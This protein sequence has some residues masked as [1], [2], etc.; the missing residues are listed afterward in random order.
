MEKIIQKALSLAGF[1]NADELV[2][3]ISATPNPRVA[4]E[5]ILGIHTPAQV[6]PE[7]RFRKYKYNSNKT[8][9]ELFAFNEL[10]DQVHV[11]VY[12]QKTKQVWYLTKEDKENN[13]FVETRPKDYYDWSNV[14]TTGYDLNEKVM[15]TSE[16]ESEY[17][18]P[19]SEDDAWKQLR[20]WDEYGLPEPVEYFVHEN[21]LPF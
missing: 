7:T 14:P 19:L 10:H 5:I 9:A 12:T 20:E 6:V 21:E 15:T 17:K 1:Q 18:T 11:M 13:K 8:I 4:A 3:V 16:F 2:K